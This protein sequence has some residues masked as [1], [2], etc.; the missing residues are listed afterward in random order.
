M[1][2]RIW[3]K[4]IRNFKWCKPFK[5]IKGKK[6]YSPTKQNVQNLW[7]ILLVDFIRLFRSFFSSA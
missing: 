2:I 3:S 7:Q 4:D 1:N 6:H 5:S